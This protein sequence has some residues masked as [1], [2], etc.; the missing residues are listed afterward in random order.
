[1]QKFNVIYEDINKQEFVAYDVMPYLRD[2]YNGAK[3][4]ERPKDITEMRLFVK[5][6]SQY[7]WWSRS[8]YEIVLKSWVSSYTKEKKIDIYWQVLLNLDVIAQM[9]LNEVMI[10]INHRQRKI[11]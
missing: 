1:M 4:S 3:K 8:E 2:C 11:K 6:W 10:N 5:K 7:M 9:L